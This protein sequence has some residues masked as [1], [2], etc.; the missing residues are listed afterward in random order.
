MKMRRIGFT[1]VEL[2]VV[3]AIIGILIALLLPAVQA[4]RE[5]ARRMQCTNNLKQLALGMHNYHSTHGGLPPGC[6][7]GPGPSRYYWCDDYTWHHTI[8]PFIEQQVYHDGFDWNVC[9]CGVV[10]EKNRQ[11]RRE[12]LP[13]F[14]CP[15]DGMAENQWTHVRFN[16]VRYNYVV[17]WGNTDSAQQPRG[18][19]EFDGAP[20]TWVTSCRFRDIADGTSN[21]LAISETITPKGPNWEGSLGEI[22]LCRGGQGFETWTGPNSDIPDIVDE[23]CPAA[24]N[25]G[26]INCT[27]GY[28]TIPPIMPPHPTGLHYGA[29]SQH[30]GGVNA[31]MCDG[32]V[33][34]FS[35]DIDLFTWRALSTTQGSEIIKDAF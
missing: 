19:E 29:R 25:V 5:A 32:S 35:D 24:G 1:L 17:N 33:H 27:I 13:V 21:T 18:M 2:L 8:T 6:L 16:R 15:S 31:A 23:T 12:K 26:G 11:A 9:A 10:N 30:P 34:F 22:S 7:R 4:A 3:I 28:P 20:F 14:A